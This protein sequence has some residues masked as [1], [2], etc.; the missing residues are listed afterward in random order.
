M[1]QKPI[2]YWIKIF[3]STILSWTA[4]FLVV[5]CV[6]MAFLSLSAY[7]NLLIFTKQLVMWLVLL[8]SPT[9][10]GSGIAE[11]LFDTF[12]G[13]FLPAG[14]LIIVTSIIWRLISYYPYLFI[15]AF[16]LPK[17]LAKR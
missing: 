17:W 13:D 5:N 1:K 4:R 7:D 6:L 14:A 8:I 12:L 10:G 3:G 15:G 16:I 9:P 11:Y 2:K